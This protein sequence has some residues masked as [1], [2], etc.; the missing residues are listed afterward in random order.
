MP[1]MEKLTMKRQRQECQKKS[2]QIADGTFVCKN[3]NRGIKGWYFSKK[4]NENFYYDSFYEFIRMNI[5]DKDNSVL[6]WSK[7]HGIKIPYLYKGKQKKYIPDFLIEYYDKKV[8]EEVKGY[9]E[10]NKKM[11]KMTALKDYAVKHNILY[12]FIEYNELNKLCL[13]I[14]GFSIKY[15][16]NK[17]K[18]S[19]EI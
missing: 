15:L 3:F 14:F 6:K 1:F 16:R 7:R 10:A 9:E 12:N 5:L 2:Q 17:F 4:M 18:E 11:V 8:L 19:K 13:D